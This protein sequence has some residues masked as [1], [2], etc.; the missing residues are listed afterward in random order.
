M[1]QNASSNSNKQLTNDQ[2]QA[3]LQALLE[4]YEEGKLKCRIIKKVAEIFMSSTIIEAAKRN[5]RNCAFGVPVIKLMD[6]I[7]MDQ[8]HNML[9]YHVLPTIKTK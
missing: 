4:N 2:W 5:S 8:Y 7:I 9:M 3:I 6:S 1:Y